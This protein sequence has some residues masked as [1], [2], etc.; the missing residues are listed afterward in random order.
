MSGR[1]DQYEPP[2]ND[3]ILQGAGSAP[4]DRLMINTTGTT[5]HSNPWGHNNGTNTA[6]HDLTKSFD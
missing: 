3:S 5:G 2:V 6:T 4:T 1:E